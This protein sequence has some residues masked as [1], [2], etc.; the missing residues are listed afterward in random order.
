MENVQRKPSATW[1]EIRESVDKA[2]Q[3]IYQKY[4]KNQ[5]IYGPSYDDGYDPLNY[6]PPEYEEHVLLRDEVIKTIT[7]FWGTYRLITDQ[8]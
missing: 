2:F 6:I 8:I 4:L 7:P 3:L 1:K 5:D